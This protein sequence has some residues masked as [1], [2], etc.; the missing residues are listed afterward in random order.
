MRQRSTLVHLPHLSLFHG[1][2][3]P[4]LQYTVGGKGTDLKFK[5]RAGVL[6]VNHLLFK[7]RLAASPACPCCGATEETVEHVLLSCPKY[8]SLRL[9]LFRGIWNLQRTHRHPGADFP[10]LSNI[11][12]AIM[13]LGDKY[14]VQKGG[15]EQANKL[16]CTYLSAMWEAREAHIQSA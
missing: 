14:W 3:Q 13:L 6:E 9:N 12:Q 16:V 4:Y 15:F 1:K 5:C 2:L 10:F 7:R 8:C 11:Q